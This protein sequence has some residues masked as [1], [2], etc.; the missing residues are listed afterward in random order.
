MKVEIEITKHEWD[1]LNKL[2]KNGDILG[3]Y[4]RLILNGTPIDQSISDN[5]IK[6]NEIVMRDATQHERDCVNN[7]LDAISVKAGCNFWDFGN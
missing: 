7:H 6:A 3:H 2:A 1:Y 4:E 5:S